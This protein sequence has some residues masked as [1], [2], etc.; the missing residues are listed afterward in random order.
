MRCLPPV[1]II[2]EEKTE[3]GFAQSEIARQLKFIFGEQFMLYGY[4]AMGVVFILFLCMCYCCFTDSSTVK[5]VEE[6]PYEAVL[7]EQE[8]LSSRKCPATAS[9]VPLNFIMTDFSMPIE[10]KAPLRIS[11]PFLTS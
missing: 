7:T 1:Y 10:P 3:K 11:H 8:L 5:P 2:V 4:V 9:I 6:A